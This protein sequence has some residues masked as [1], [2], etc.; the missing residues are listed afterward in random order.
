[1]NLFKRFQRLLPKQS[2]TIG[3]VVAHNSADVTSTIQTP[4][5]STYRAKGQ[6]VAIGKNAFVSNGAIVSEAPSLPTSS[7][8]I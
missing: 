2:T 4:S 5:G 3:L 6:S 8:T 7:E 1:M